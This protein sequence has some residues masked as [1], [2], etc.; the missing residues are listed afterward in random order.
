MVIG[1]LYLQRTAIDDRL[2]AW[3]HEGKARPGRQAEHPMAFLKLP[4]V[5]LCFS[6]FFWTTA[7]L[8]TC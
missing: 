5:W 7:A 6:F 4:S 2:G 3:A 8:S 1:L